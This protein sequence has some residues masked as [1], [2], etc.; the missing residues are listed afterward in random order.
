MPRAKQNHKKTHKEAENDG[1]SLLFLNSFKCAAIALAISLGLCAL[2]AAA[3]LML[4]DPLGLITPLA[5]CALYISSFL[6]G[7]LCMK[8]TR[9]GTLLCGVLSGSIFML[10]YMLISL[11]MPPE[12]SSKHSFLT[13]LLL[14]ALILVFSVIGAYTAKHSSGKKRKIRR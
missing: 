6:S 4:S 12:L 13:S 9:E 3:M 10:F 5:L 11:F 1:F 14:H 8:K 2:L 7:F